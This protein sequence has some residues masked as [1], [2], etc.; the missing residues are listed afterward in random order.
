MEERRVEGREGPKPGRTAAFSSFLPALPVLIKT[1][2]GAVVPPP[3]PTPQAASTP[4]GPH[5]QV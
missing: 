1:A 2:A 5:P 4:P 3:V